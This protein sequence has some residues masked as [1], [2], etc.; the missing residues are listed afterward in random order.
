MFILRPAQCL[1]VVTA[2]ASPLGAVVGNV[3]DKPVS[4][5]GL[6]MSRPMICLILAGLMFLTLLVF[7][8]QTRLD[9]IRTA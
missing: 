8:R 1:L 5:G 9:E 7:R 2:S 6:A 4:H 3:L